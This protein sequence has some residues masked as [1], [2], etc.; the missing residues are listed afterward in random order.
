ME[1]RE[2]LIEA[3]KQRRSRDLNDHMSL[4]EAGAGKAPPVPQGVVTREAAMTQSP[5]QKYAHD[6]MKETGDG[7]M[8]EEEDSL[9][10]GSDGVNPANLASKDGRDMDDSSQDV[11]GD[12]DDD[13]SNVIEKS[14]GTDAK[15]GLRG[16]AMA[17]FKE[18]GA[19]NTKG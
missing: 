19:K 6:P 1:M 8:T 17:M 2:D 3:I 9:V 12:A 7:Y 16:R 13:E 15:G 4:S 10:G 14:L 5:D 11:P 18:K